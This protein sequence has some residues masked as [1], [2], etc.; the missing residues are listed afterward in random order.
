MSGAVAPAAVES[1]TTTTM[2]VTEGG[3]AD[4]L[5]DGEVGGGVGDGADGGSSDG[6]SDGAD[7]GTGDGAEAAASPARRAPHRLRLRAL[8]KNTEESTAP[9]QVR[10]VA[11]WTAEGEAL[12]LDESHELAICIEQCT[13]CRTGAKQGMSLRGNENRYVESKDAVLDK[14]R[15]A[16][17]WNQKQL[18]VTVN[19]DVL[20]TELCHPLNWMQPCPYD[21]VTGGPPPRY[22]SLEVGYNLQIGGEEVGGG[23]VY[24]KLAKG[25]FPNPAK[26]GQTL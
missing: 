2:A 20:P 11:C 10:S 24:S 1:P 23:R 19:P 22:G 3:L 8:T 16:F 6:A 5:A 18:T 15:A 7:D 9:R 14:V 26:V 4:G 17:V 12:D 13:A 25:R 21:G